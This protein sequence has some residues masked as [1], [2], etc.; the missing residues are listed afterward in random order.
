MARKRPS[1]I[2]QTL[3]RLD[4]LKRF[5]QSKHL[6]KQEERERSI[7]RGEK[8][9][10]ARVDGIYSYKTYAVYK[11]HSLKFVTWA[12]EKHGSRTLEQAREHVREY[13]QE[14]IRDGRSAWTVRV[15]AAALA[16][17]YGCSSNS[18]GVEL[19]SRRREDIHRSREEREHDRKFSE[20][21]NRDLI[22]FCRGTGLR[23]KELSIVRPQ[24]V[25]QKGE[26]VYIRVIRGK[27]GKERVLRV[28]EEYK[29][30]VLKV[31]DRALERGQ[32]RLFERIPV[33]ADIHSYRRDYAE[34]RY[35]EIE[36]DPIQYERA[37]E[38][39]EAWK[40]ERGYDGPD[41]YRRRDGRVFDRAILLKVSRD[42]GHNRVDVI[43]RHYLD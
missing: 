23:R 27:G 28:V 30:H 4:E 35:R 5:G 7:E 18:F 40:H 22:E 34:E 32:E 6:A 43:A 8:Y 9:N 37:L 3:M 20:E 19:P 15:E 21:K 25:V 39:W 42:M 26:E 24:D 41:E 16:K 31:R 13:L 1:I 12:R 11:E 2:K 17:L 33:R 36:R 38:R 14:H 29:E 10:P